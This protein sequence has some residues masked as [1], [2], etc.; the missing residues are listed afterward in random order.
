MQACCVPR[1]MD[2]LTLLYH[3]TDG[4]IVLNTFPQMVVT[5]CGCR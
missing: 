5:A 1:A 3:D 2:S 4:E